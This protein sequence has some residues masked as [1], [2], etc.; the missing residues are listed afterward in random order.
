M[1]VTATAPSLDMVLSLVR[2]TRLESNS[3]KHNAARPFPSHLHYRLQSLPDIQA[4]TS[5]RKIYYR[6]GFEYL[7]LSAVSAVH[8]IYACEQTLQGLPES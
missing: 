8:K 5:N 7:R 6:N 1:R 4:S 3:W 2:G